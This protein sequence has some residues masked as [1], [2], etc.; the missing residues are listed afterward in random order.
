MLWVQGQEQGEK[1]CEAPGQAKTG[2]AAPMQGLKVQV[3]IK[4]II[5]NYGSE[6]HER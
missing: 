3:Q 5:F 1:G 2:Q 6:I 4:D